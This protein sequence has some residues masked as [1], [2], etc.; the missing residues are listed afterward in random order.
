VSVSAPAGAGVSNFGTRVKTRI[1]TTTQTVQNAV[2]SHQRELTDTAVGIRMWPMIPLLLA[3]GAILY[4]QGG[5]ST[6]GRHGDPDAW[7]RILTE[8][9]LGHFLAQNTAGMYPLLGLVLAA[10]RGGTADTP[11]EKIK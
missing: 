3:G 2:L 7:K 1:T 5:Q 8:A 10:Y 11:L 6:P 9:L 4:N